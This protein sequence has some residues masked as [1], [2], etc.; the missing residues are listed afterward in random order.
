MEMELIFISEISQLAPELYAW[1]PML[2]NAWASERFRNDVTWHIKM[3]ELEPHLLGDRP[4]CLSSCACPGTQ[5]KT[6]P[7]GTS[8]VTQWLRIRLPM[9][10]TQVQALVW[11]DP[12]CR[13]ATKPVRHN[14][15]ACALELASHNY[16]AWA[17]ELASHNY[18]ACALELASHNYWACTPQL[19]KPM[20]LEPVHHNKRSHCNEKPAQSH[21]DPMQP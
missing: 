17:L 15:W 9:Q 21:E 10:G 13:R 1:L 5:R 14:Y 19:L 12:T 4:L 11:E 20:C 6:M 8:L 16:W 2:R 3:W 7:W 18:W